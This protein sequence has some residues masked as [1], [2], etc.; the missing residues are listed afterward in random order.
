MYL[1][2]AL[3]VITLGVVA[4]A[5]AVATQWAWS[6]GPGQLQFQLQPRQKVAPSAAPVSPQMQNVLEADPARLLERIGALEQ[7]V[8]ALET[9]LAKHKHEY[10]NLVHG[11]YACEIFR[12]ARPLPLNDQ[13]APRA[14]RDQRNPILG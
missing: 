10:R 9:R 3:A 6:Q 8:T 13:R 2:V 14:E 7:K 11:H 5:G 1:R 4:L 12:K